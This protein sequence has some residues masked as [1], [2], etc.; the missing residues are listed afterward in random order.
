MCAVYYIQC[1][2]RV[3]LLFSDFYGPWKITFLLK[4][5]VNTVQCDPKIVILIPLPCVYRYV[6]SILILNGNLCYYI[7]M[8]FLS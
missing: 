2:I 3:F 8:T 7:F 1:I 4:L 5:M 6:V